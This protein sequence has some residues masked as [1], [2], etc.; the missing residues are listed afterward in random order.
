MS[1]PEEIDM[2]TATAVTIRPAV[3]S[4]R[5][6]LDR[7]AALDSARPLTGDVLVAEVEGEHLAAIE[8]ASARAIADPFRHTA[9]L[10]AMLSGRV[11]ALRRTERRP[12][13]RVRFALRALAG[14]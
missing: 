8:I 10:V 2:T 6:A 14:H 11:T 3:E 12:R 1:Q 4:D 13:P 9:D 5:T 7:L